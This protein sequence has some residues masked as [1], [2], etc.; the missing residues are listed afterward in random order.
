MFPGLCICLAEISLKH[1]LLVVEYIYVELQVLALFDLHLL[2]LDLV[3]QLAQLALI[4][5]LQGEDLADRAVDALV[6]FLTC[7]LL[8]LCLEG[9]LA[10]LGV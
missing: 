3:L 9:C 5:P 8:F 1:R 7:L 2:H 4:A 10:E 6:G